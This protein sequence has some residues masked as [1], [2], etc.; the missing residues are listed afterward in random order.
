MIKKEFSS[1]KNLKSELEV[2]VKRDSRSKLINDAYVNSLKKRYNVNSKQPALSYFTSI[3]NDNYF[4]RTWKLPEDFDSI[5]PLIKI[6]NKQLLYKDFGDFLVKNQRRA[7]PKMSYRAIVS[8]N[9]QTFFNNSL[10]L[11]Q[12]D[13]LEH[14]NED[15][16]HILGEY[17]DGLL[18]FDVME[19][20]IWNA[21]KTDSIGFKNYYNT[22]KNNYFWDERVD[23]IVASSANQDV[24][25]KVSEL[26]KKGDNTDLIKETINTNN[27]VNVIFTSGLMN[28]QHQALPQT[29]K[30]S[31]G[32]SKIYKHNNAYVVILVK[33]MLPKTIKTLDEAKGRVIND[34]QLYTENIW[35]ESLRKKYTVSINQEALNKVKSQINNQ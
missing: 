8:E 21:A 32:V 27:K 25:K 26:F 22:H 29:F 30:F 31:K 18:L 5:K 4:K 3:L 11:Y 23:A 10:I 15:F 1:L 6:G 19:T 13:N 33:N 9:Y 2:K 20:K 16:A 12:E 28:A 14:E 24:I 7:T 35:L 17:R 34:F